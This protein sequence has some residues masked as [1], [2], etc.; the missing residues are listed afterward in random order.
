LNKFKA[1][2]FV[3]SLVVIFLSMTKYFSENEVQIDYATIEN[4]D[5]SELNYIDYGNNSDS[6]NYALYIYDYNCIF[7]QELHPTIIDLIE[8]YNFNFKMVPT[9]LLGNDSGDL[10]HLAYC[11]DEIG[12][13]GYGHNILITNDDA[14]NYGL[15]NKYDINDKKINKINKCFEESLYERYIHENQVILEKNNIN[16]VPLVIVNDRA[17]YGKRDKEV[18]LKMLKN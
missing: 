15:V 11:Y 9:S 16:S 6:A 14:L 8:K 1:I 5:L 17:I 18:Y 7:C 10:A 3:T 12:E 13:F 4:L 2:L